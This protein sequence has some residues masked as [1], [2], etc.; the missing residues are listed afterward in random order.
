MRL[1]FARLHF[2]RLHFARLHFV[3]LHFVRLHFVRLHFVHFTLCAEFGFTQKKF[4]L[5]YYLPFPHF[6]RTFYDIFLNFFSKCWLLSLG[7]RFSTGRPQLVRHLC[8]KLLKNRTNINLGQVHTS[9]SANF[10]QNTT[11]IKI[12]PKIALFEVLVETY[13]NRIISRIALIKWRTNQ[14]Y[15]QVLR[16]MKTKL[17][18][19]SSV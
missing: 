4:I 15:L 17:R 19:L 7:Q 18:V 3:R 9:I 13:K 5:C 6:V 16:P 1:H 12:S 8:Q 10:P 2:A 14:G 11:L